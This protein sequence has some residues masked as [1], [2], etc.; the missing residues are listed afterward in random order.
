MGLR[1]FFLLSSKVKPATL[2]QRL[3][4]QID[5]RQKRVLFL[6]LFISFDH[7]AGYIKFRIIMSFR[8]PCHMPFCKL[9][10]PFTLT[11]S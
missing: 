1:G 2:K 7:S 11:D 10:P 9:I 4:L 5:W 8:K 3:R 6:V